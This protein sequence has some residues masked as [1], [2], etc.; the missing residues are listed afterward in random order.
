MN[1]TIVDEIRRLLP[2]RL[3]KASVDAAGRLLLEVYVRVD[4]THGDK[5]F[6][7]VDALDVAVAHERPAR[8]ADGDSAPPPAI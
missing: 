3:Q 7:V 1:A 2:A 4:D 8:D 6:I 5:R